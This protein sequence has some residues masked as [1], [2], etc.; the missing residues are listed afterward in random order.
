VH[1]RSILKA[2]T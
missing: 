1:V 2:R